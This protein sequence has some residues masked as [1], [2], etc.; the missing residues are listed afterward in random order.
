LNCEICESPLIPGSTQP[1]LVPASSPLPSPPPYTRSW[2][3]AP[4]LDDPPS[5]AP[6]VVLPPGASSDNGPCFPLCAA[7]C[8][9]KILHLSCTCRHRWTRAKRVDG[10][11]SRAAPSPVRA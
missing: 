11:C 7:F 6:T 9:I 8:S 2:A 5:G 3:D 4:V 10:S 1:G